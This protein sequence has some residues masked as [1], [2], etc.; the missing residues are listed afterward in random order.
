M[1]LKNKKPATIDLRAFILF[2]LLSADRTGLVPVIYFIE[3]ELLI[4]LLDFLLD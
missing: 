1:R 4:F 2:A 3:K